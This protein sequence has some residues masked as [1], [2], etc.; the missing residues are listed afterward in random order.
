MRIYI[1]NGAPGSG[2]TTFE[3]LVRQKVGSDWVFILSTIDPIKQA[4]KFL[5]W[6]GVKDPKARKFLSD[7]KDLANSVYDT[8]YRYIANEINKIEKSFSVYDMPTDDVVVFID[9]REP[10]DIQRLSLMYNAKTILIKRASGADDAEILNHADRDVEL[11][12][13]DI[14]IENDGDLDWLSKKVDDFIEDEGIKR[15][16]R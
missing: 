16:S 7:L 12:E 11:F 6:T 10:W 8:S 15:P 5:G 14:Y 1:V 9:S 4:A 3:T 2:K 13:Y